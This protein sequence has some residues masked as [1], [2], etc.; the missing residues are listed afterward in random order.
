VR[1]ASQQAQ[2]ARLQDQSILR[3]GRKQ[4]KPPFWVAPRFLASSLIWVEAHLEIWQK[5]ECW[6]AWGI[7]WRRCGSYE[8]GRVRMTS[9]TLLD[10]RDVLK[11]LM[12]GPV[13]QDPCELISGC[14]CQRRQLRRFYMGGFRMTMRLRSSSIRSNAAKLSLFSNSVR[15][16][17]SNI[18]S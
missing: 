15:F 1:S 9:A 17:S 14:C 12:R 11:R 2:R 8:V 18:C 4:R 16:V 7:S 6:P 13:L 3:A 10:L 5:G